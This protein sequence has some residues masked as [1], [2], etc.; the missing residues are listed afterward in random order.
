MA[1]LAP[2]SGCRRLPDCPA[3]ASLRM[4]KGTP[5][6]AYTLEVNAFRSAENDK[7]R[8]VPV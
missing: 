8:G 5:N 2:P 1:N 6:P 4:L 7:C 3:D